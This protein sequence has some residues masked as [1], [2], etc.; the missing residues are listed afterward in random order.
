[1]T[2]KRSR[3]PT[4]PQVKRVA[5]KCKHRA[6]QTNCSFKLSNLVQL[7]SV[8]TLFQTVWQQ[9]GIMALQI[10]LLLQFTPSAQPQHIML[11]QTDSLLTSGGVAQWLERQSITG[12][13]SL[14]CAMTC[15]WWVTVCCMSANMAN[16]A[17]HPLGVDKRVVSWTQAFAMLIC[18]VALPGNA[19]G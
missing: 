19:Y 8:I 10:V 16:S 14:A 9:F 6:L 7:S 5:V 13:L 4:P 18:L 3:C 12:E 17:I 1:M 2:G 15:S 11:V